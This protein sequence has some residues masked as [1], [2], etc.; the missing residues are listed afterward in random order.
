M[1]YNVICTTHTFKFEESNE[2]PIADYILLTKNCPRVP[3]QFCTCFDIPESNKERL[4]LKR[5]V[6][7]CLLKL[8]MTYKIA[9]KGDA[10]SVS[11][12]SA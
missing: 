7:E 8:R 10:L 5:E 2:S 3:L 6:L 11:G 1:Y 4:G 12:S 9:G